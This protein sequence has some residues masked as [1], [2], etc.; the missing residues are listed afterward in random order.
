MDLFAPNNG[1]G[2]TSFQQTLMQSIMDGVQD[3]KPNVPLSFG[4]RPHSASTAGKAILTGVPNNW[5]IT[6]GGEIYNVLI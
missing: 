4:T 5:I 2:G 3:R 6:D 1:G